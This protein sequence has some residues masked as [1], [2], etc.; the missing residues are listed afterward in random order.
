MK[1]QTPNNYHPILVR[2]HWLIFFLVIVALGLGKF[3][4]T[5]PNNADKIPFLGLHMVLGF[6]IL[7]AMIARLITRLRLPNPPYASTGN[8]IL[9]LIGKLVHFGLYLFVFLMALSGLSLSLQSGLAPIVFGNSGSVLPEDFYVYSARVL[10]GFVGP[11]LL[12]LI[13]FH[14]AA[15]F[16]HQLIL[17]DNLFSRMAIN[18]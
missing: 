2:M 17:K 6:L 13:L 10:H 1:E 12:G 14:A 16:Y 18:K 8:K 9:D 4:S 11:V 5:L 15:A 7:F 3:M